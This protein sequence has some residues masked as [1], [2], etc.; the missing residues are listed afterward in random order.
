[1]QREIKPFLKIFLTSL[2]L[3]YLYLR[4]DFTQFTHSR[5]HTPSQKKFKILHLPKNTIKHKISPSDPR[6]SLP[7]NTCNKMLV[8][9][10]WHNFK[11]YK[12]AQG[13]ENYRPTLYD[14]FGNIQYSGR[15]LAED[16]GVVDYSSELLRVCLES[17]S[18]S[19]FAKNIYIVGDSRSRLLY[20]IL[21]ARL[22]NETFIQDYKYHG[23]I[24]D[25]ST[26]IKYLWSTSF[27]GEKVL[28]KDQADGLKYL[29][30]KVY[31]SS[32][33]RPEMIIVGE[34][35]LHPAVDTGRFWGKSIFDLF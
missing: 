19:Q 9:G 25:Q 17:T 33:E 3:T 11:F 18:E 26:N 15:F 5:S 31:M 6:N 13:E 12:K 29:K 2:G 10:R 30:E 14:K 34:H 16:C 22:K 21:T 8:Y 20:K 24:S 35:F 27:S 1:M 23:D 4:F 7:N 28:K 32:F